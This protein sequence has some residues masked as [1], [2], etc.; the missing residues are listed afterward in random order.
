MMLLLKQNEKTELG[1]G[2]YVLGCC[3]CY[4]PI[5]GNGHCCMGSFE[6]FFRDL[7]DPL[8]PHFQQVYLPPRDIPLSWMSRWKLVKG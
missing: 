1:K 4:P 5:L 7:G 6:K 8:P 2:V 3:G